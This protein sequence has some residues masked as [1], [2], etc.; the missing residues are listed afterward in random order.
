MTTL[1]KHFYLPKEIFSNILSYNDYSKVRHKEKQ[2]DINNFFSNLQYFKNMD[3]ETF[4]SKYG[5]DGDIDMYEEEIIFEIYEYVLD[6]YNYS[7][8]PIIK[9]LTFYE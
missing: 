8:L 4:V 2:K 1:S 6:E 3:Y 7:K 5:Y 9:Y